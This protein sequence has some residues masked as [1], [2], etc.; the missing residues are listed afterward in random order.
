MDMFEILL[1]VFGDDAILV[2]DAISGLQSQLF[3]SQADM[4]GLTVNLEK[5]QILL[6]LTE[7]D[8]YQQK[9]CGF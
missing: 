4:W 2:S 6:F 3:E 8:A 7:V 9:R 5:N 1:F